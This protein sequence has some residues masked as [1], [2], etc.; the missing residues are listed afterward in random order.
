MLGMLL[1]RLDTGRGA[2]VVGA[3]NGPGEHAVL[4]PI[5]GEPR[6]EFCEEGPGRPAEDVEESIVH[7]DVPRGRR[8]R[9]EDYEGFRVGGCELGGEKG[10]GNVEDAL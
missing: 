1:V 3:E 2:V 8:A 9:V 4:V 6:V 10:A 5:P 7:G